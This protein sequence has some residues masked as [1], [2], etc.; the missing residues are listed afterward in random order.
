MSLETKATTTQSTAKPVELPILHLDSEGGA[1]ILLQQ[2]L[3][4]HRYRT[5][6]ID[7]KFGSKTEQ[8]VKTFQKTFGLVVDGIVGAKTWNKLGD[9]LINP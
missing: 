4:S 1:V 5:G 2:L 7:G 3:E 6:G 8:A 9:R